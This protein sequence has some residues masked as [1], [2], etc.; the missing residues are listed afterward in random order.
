MQCDC[1]ASLLLI[2][3][4]SKSHRS[5]VVVA[6]EGLLLRRYW[7][8]SR[9]CFVAETRGLRTFDDL[10]RGNQREEVIQ[11]TGRKTDRKEKENIL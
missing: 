9:F 8:T 4:Q 5:S 10:Q 7:Y 3:S 1:T 11:E 2:K 6:L